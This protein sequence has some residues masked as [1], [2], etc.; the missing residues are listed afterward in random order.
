M[1]EPVDSATM[2]NKDIII[3]RISSTLK[4]LRNYYHY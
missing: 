3:G 2:F 1:D 4:L